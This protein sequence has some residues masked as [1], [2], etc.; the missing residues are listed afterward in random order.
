M[1]A[2]KIPADSELHDAA[3]TA[4][5]HDAFEMVVNDDRTAMALYLAAVTGTP[6]WVNLLLTIRNRVVSLF[7]L[8]D[9]GHLS[10]ID[11]SKIAADYKPGDRVGI[12]TLLSVSSHEVVLGDADK[13]LDARL[14][15]YKH[16]GAQPKVVVSTVVHVHNRLGRLYLFFVVPVH[17]IIVP[18]M[19]A[20]GFGTRPA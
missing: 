10:D 16:A 6:R 14:S 9:V 5:F 4:Y 3:A 13:H 15:L 20:R 2:A 12:F 19:L 17:K 8:K 1:H 18:A 11:R 7:G